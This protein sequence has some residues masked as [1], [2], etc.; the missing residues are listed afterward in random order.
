TETYQ[1]NIGKR[2]ADMS[3]SDRVKH[4]QWDHPLRQR[5]ELDKGDEVDEVELIGHRADR[6]PRAARLLVEELER[7]GRWR[8]HAI[9]L[10]VTVGDARRVGG[11]CTE[12]NPSLHDDALAR[13]LFRR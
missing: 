12:L 2:R 4:I 9:L 3:G 13:H 11:F 8:R 10:S 6:Q 5:L 7:R 1:G